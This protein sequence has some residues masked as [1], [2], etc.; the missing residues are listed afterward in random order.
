MT[1]ARF[2][3]GSGKAYL[4]GVLRVA[5]MTA[6][7]LVVA[8]AVSQGQT[9]P[10]EGA[11]ASSDGRESNAPKPENMTDAQKREAVQRYIAFERDA[12]GSLTALI[13]EARSRRDLLQ[14][15]CLN[16]KQRQIKALLKISETAATTMFDAMGEGKTEQVNGQF[17]RIA[18]AQS[19]VQSIRNDANACVGI[20]AVYSGTTQIEVEVS[21]GASLAD[22]TNPIPPPAGPPLPPVASGS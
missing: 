13:Q 6:L 10:N 12:L 22:P 2:D 7:A 17:T 18:L 11:S 15:N 3:S 4:T 14:L 20:E 21:D 8:P 9:G 5:A 1:Q 19:R 16:E